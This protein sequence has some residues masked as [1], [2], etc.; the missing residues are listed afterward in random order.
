M[1]PLLFFPLF[2]L[3]EA[4]SLPPLSISLTKLSSNI[5]P[6]EKQRFV[7]LYRTESLNLANLSKSI[8]IISVFCLWVVTPM[9]LGFALTTSSSLHSFNFT[10]VCR[11]CVFRPV[12]IISWSPRY[13]TKRAH[14]DTLTHTD[15]IWH[16]LK[17]GKHKYNCISPDSKNHTFAEGGWQMQR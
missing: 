5:Q 6:A 7:Q 2:P 3:T 17:C 11:V 4:Q 13:Q 14:T 10:L 9:R 8:H 1:R 16:T 15:Q 12:V